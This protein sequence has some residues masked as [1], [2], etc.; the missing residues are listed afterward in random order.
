[1]SR[2]DHHA[3]WRLWDHYGLTYHRGVRLFRCTPHGSAVAEDVRIATR[4]ARRKA[5]EEMRRGLE[6]APYRHRHQ[7]QWDAT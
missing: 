1:M 2:T 7:V 6:P 3:P 5:R 4:R